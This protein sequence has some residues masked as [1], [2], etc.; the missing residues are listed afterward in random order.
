MYDN[1]FNYYYVLSDNGQIYLRIIFEI[2]SALFS[3]L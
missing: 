3:S 1:M 2:D